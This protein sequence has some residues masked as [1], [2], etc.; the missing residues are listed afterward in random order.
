MKKQLII[1]LIAFFIP[2]IF[3]GVEGTLTNHAYYPG[4]SAIIS[5]NVDEEFVGI[6]TL[7]I[8]LSNYDFNLG[9]YS[10]KCDTQLLTQ[11]ISINNQYSNNII[12][13][14]NNIPSSVYRF[15]IQLKYK[16]NGVS[17]TRTD[18]DDGNFI[19]I[20][21]SNNPEIILL[22]NTGITLGAIS[23][24]IANPNSQVNVYVNITNIDQEGVI[25][26]SSFIKNQTNYINENLNDDSF[27]ILNITKG[28][29]AI[30]LM[31]NKIIENVTPGIYEYIIKAESETNIYQTVNSIEILKL[32]EIILN[33]SIKIQENNITCPICETCKECET[34]TCPKVNNQSQGQTSKITAKLNLKRDEYYYIP[35]IIIGIIS[36]IIMY[37]KIK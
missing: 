31:K 20:K 24:Q 5:I 6:G 9:K 22:K 21:Q 34:I 13:N 35:T 4:E 18:C 28:S 37:V 33:E 32:N 36:L 14:L 2:K 19:L 17:K 16:I 23:S 3:A 27:K 26:L 25:L 7:K 10:S 8:C 29:S 11:N 15:Y 12:I 30:I 1:I